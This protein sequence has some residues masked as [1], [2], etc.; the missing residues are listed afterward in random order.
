MKQGFENRPDFLSQSR[1][2]R[3]NTTAKSAIIQFSAHNEESFKTFLK[4]IEK[5]V[6]KSFWVVYTDEAVAESDGGTLKTS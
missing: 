4:K 2:N 6:D 5:V 1:K 3:M